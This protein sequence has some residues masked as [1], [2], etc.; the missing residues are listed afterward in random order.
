M[1]V[2]ARDCEISPVPMANSASC[3]AFTSR[4]SHPKPELKIGGF[5]FAQLFRLRINERLIKRVLMLRV[6]GIPIRSSPNSPRKVLILIQRT[7][8][9]HFG[10]I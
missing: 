1:A 8:R 5:T 4:F 9:L 6:N 10:T 3:L 7:F 2:A